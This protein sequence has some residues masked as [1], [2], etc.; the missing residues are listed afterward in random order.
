MSDLGWRLR[1]DNISIV[2]C[3]DDENASEDVDS[4]EQL[5]GIL[6][7]AGPTELKFLETAHH[8]VFQIVDSLTNDD[9]LARLDELTRALTTAAGERRWTTDNLRAFVAGLPRQEPASDS[10]SAK[11]AGVFAGS[12][13][14]FQRFTFA[15]WVDQSADVIRRAAP[16]N[17]LLL[18][19]DLTNNDPST[20]VDGV[21]VLARL[22]HDNASIRSCIDCIVV[23]SMHE[24][25][26][27][28]AGSQAI[29]QQVREKVATMGE[30][31]AHKVFV[32]SKARLAEEDATVQKQMIVHFDRLK[33]SR[34][35]R[36]LA[37]ASRRLL[38][39]AVSEATDWLEE[40]SLPEFHWSVFRS[41]QQEGTSEIQ[42][43]LRL[44]SLKQGLNLENAFPSDP[45]IME[46]ITGLRSIP[47]QSV[48]HSETPQEL[49]A[50][51]RL[52]FERE[53]KHV[54]RLRR[55]VVCGD[56][57]AF[58]GRAGGGPQKTLEAILLGNPCDLSLREDGKRNAK[59]GFLIPIE[60]RMVGDDVGKLAIVFKT[61]DRPTDTQYVIRP[62]KM[63][64][65]PLSILDLVWLNDDGVARL[66]ADT[67][68]ALTEALSLSQQK[69]GGRM[70]ANTFQ[71]LATM[72]VFG[73]DLKPD[74]TKVKVAGRGQVDEVQYPVART[75]RMT[76][77]YA[78]AALLEFS[79]TMARPAF[80]HDFIRGWVVQDRRSSL[81]D[82]ETEPSTSE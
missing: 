39:E 9:E 26:T 20:S 17:R 79:Q 67:V 58:T 51:R 71:T 48:E 7:L 35:G 74:L 32:L 33:A 18:L 55:P 25:D 4:V 77:D 61:G 76:Q 63:A 43:L 2:C 37:E 42:T 45:K 23:T 31:K 24:P 41:S 11:L 22:F 54:N 65:V 8:D 49:E 80:G 1:A 44:V 78:A 3:I 5:A 60:R 28:L 47:R 21:E 10:I 14:E 27:E 38:Q 36:D 19:I 12:G 40:V 64:V 70:T 52:E 34:L 13:A 82:V 16:D 15:E 68:P 81:V 6:A 66:P 53:G 50:M 59:V 57:F 72:Q 56:V 62:N 75:W 29:Y 73:L 69:A 30:T 46:A